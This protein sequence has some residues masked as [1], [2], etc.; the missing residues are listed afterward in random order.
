MSHPTPSSPVG[1]EPTRSDRVRSGTV[2]RRGARGFAA[3]LA[4]L[5]LIGGAALV[6]TPPAQASP[7]TRGEAFSKASTE[8]G[9]PADLLQAVSY[10]QTRWDA[11]AGEHNTDGGYGPMNLIDG[12]L[13]AGDRGEAKDGN[14]GGSAPQQVD[15]LGRAAKLLGVSRAKLRNDAATNVRGGAALLAAQQRSLKL[16]TG[17]AV[18]PGQWYAAV[19]STSGATT[20]SAAGTFA[21]DVYDALAD[22]ADRTTDDGDR[23]TMAATA[24]HPKTDQLA[25]LNLRPGSKTKGV[26]CPAGV[27]C[28]SIPAPYEETGDGDYGNYDKASRDTE[29]GPSVDYIVMHDTEGSWDTS[30]KLVQD[31]TYLAWH[32]TIRSADGHIAQHVPTKDVGWHAGNWYINQHSIGIEQEGFAAEGATWYTESLYRNSARLVK[33]LAAKWDIP[34][35]HDH[36]LGHDNVPG[37]TAETVAGMHWDPGPYWDW[38][39]YFKLLGAPIKSGKGKPSKDIVRI[40]PAFDRNVQVM[41]GCTAAGKVCSPQGSN[42]VY[43]HTEP[44]AAAPL[45]KDVDLHTDGSASTIDVADIGA[46]AATGQEFAVA[47]RKGDWVA[48]WYLGQ[49]AWFHNPAGAHRTAIK[50][51]GTLVEPKAGVDAVPTYGR[52]YPEPS[53]Y[54]EGVPDQGTDPLSYQLRAGQRAVLTDSTVSTDY[55]RA[56]EF[57]G[58]PPDDHIDIRGKTKYLQISFGHRIMY[59]KADDVKVVKAG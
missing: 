52:A 41:T 27:D 58:T 6:A 25:L 39:H 56:T 7:P 37:T 34:L 22:G 21:D 38:Q 30:L 19:A 20:R 17:A 46:R 50:V 9:V 12:T 49:K 26:E 54:P 4:A 43:L 14:A 33:Y 53:A 10:A 59:V 11:H 45:V 47:D 16:P 31:P 28:E 36:I 57:D 51:G 29:A 35:D 1:P 24:A 8:F 55:Y 48:I 2:P 32:Y 3:S 23:V 15:S 44:N 5:T 18:D 42:F 13:F 40:A